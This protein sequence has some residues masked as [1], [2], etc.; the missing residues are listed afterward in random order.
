MTLWGNNNWEIIF[1]AN[2]E[3]K[4]TEKIIQDKI[5]LSTEEIDDFFRNVI[6]LLIEISKIN[7]MIYFDSFVF[8]YDKEKINMIIGDFDRVEIDEDQSP[9]EDIIDVNI[10]RFAT[11]LSKM[12]QYF[13][14]PDTDISNTFYNFIVN[15]QKQNDPIISNF[16]SLSRINR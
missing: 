9:F 15:L 1:S 2:N 13:D 10:R 12:K 14:L 7:I 5:I 4:D 3:S 6:N 16:K 11:C 8:N